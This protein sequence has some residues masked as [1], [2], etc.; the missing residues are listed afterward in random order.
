MHTSLQTC[1]QVD[2]LDTLGGRKL[3][4]VS[5][6]FWNS[7][8]NRKRP[9][10]TLSYVPEAFFLALWRGFWRPRTSLNRR[11]NEQNNVSARALYILVHFFA[12]LWKTMTLNDQIQSFVEN[13]NTRQWFI[14]FFLK[15]SAMPTNSVF[16]LQQF[17]SIYFTINLQ[18]SY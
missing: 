7:P 11:L 6:Q 4:I 14:F 10:P 18:L 13:V 12:V 2:Q 9:L 16:F 5:Q 8:F 17:F 1:W 3:V 15:L